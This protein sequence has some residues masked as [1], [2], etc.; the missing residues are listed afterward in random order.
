V[1]GDSQLKLAL[2]RV[3]VVLMCE[4]VPPCCWGWQ[5]L[6]SPPHCY[7]RHLDKP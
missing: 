5:F 7:W 3:S 4:S 6:C 2:C 1:S